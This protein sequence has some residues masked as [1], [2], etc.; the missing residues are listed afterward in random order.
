[1]ASAPVALG[2]TCPLPPADCTGAL[3]CGGEWDFENGFYETAH[4]LAGQCD[5]PPGGGNESCVP[6]DKKSYVGTGWTHWASFP[7]WPTPGYWGTCSFNENKNCANVFRGNRSQE[8]TMTFANG[9]GVIYKQAAVPAGHHIQVEAFMK[10]TPNEE[11]WPDVEHAIGIDPSGGTDPAS[12]SVEWTI[13]QEQVPS[14]PQ[15]ASVFNRGT[16]ET[17]A[18]G[19]TITVFIRQ[20]AFE[21]NGQG[22]TFMIDNV[23]IFDLGMAGPALSVSPTTLSNSAIIGFQPPDQSLSVQNVGADSLS[24]S[25]SVDEDWLSVSP[26][27]GSSSGEVNTLTVSYDASDLDVG[28]HEATISVDA[29]AIINS[30]QTVGVTLVIRTKPGDFDNDGDVDLD[31]YGFFQACFS[32]AGAPVGPECKAADFDGDHDVDGQDFTAFMGCVSGQSV[33]SDPFCIQ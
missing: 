18:Q 14:P 25:V 21:P 13:W 26:D 15:P 20:R 31:D 7:T 27:S 16:A 4:Y 3:H 22:Q 5:A 12:P 30:P 2:Q 8:L 19:S 24:Y 33:P 17:V 9:V 28:T 6:A 10:F 23:R 32:G 29:G 1:M 11:G